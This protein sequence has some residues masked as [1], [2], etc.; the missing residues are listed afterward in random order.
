MGKLDG[1]VAVYLWDAATGKV[2]RP[3]PGT[4]E[5]WQVA[6]CPD[7]RRL[8][9]LDRTAL[10]IWDADTGKEQFVLTLTPDPAVKM[11]RQLV[12][13]DVYVR[14]GWA[15]GGKY[16]AALTS[17]S[18]VALTEARVTFFDAATGKAKGPP[19][20]ALALNGLGNEVWRWSPD[21]QRL[22]LAGRTRLTGPWG[23][24]SVTA[25]NAAAGRTLFQRQ[26][27]VAETLAWS[28]DSRR[29]LVRRPDESDP[30]AY[31][32]DTGHLMAARP[33]D[34]QAA[35]GGGPMDWTGFPMGNTPVR[36]GSPDGR[37]LARV[38][39][40]T[41]HVW[42]ATR[43]RREVP[44]FLY[45][46]FEHVSPDGTLAVSPK[47]GLVR[48]VRTE[49]V[50]HQLGVAGDWIDRVT[51]SPDGRWLVTVAT[52]TASSK[53][54]PPP[55]ARTDLRVRD[56]TTGAEAAYLPG[57]AE[58]YWSR[59]GRHF[60]YFDG[61]YV[62][63]RDP[64]RGKDVRRLPRTINGSLPPWAMTAGPPLVWSPDGRRLLARLASGGEQWIEVWDMASGRAL[65]SLILAGAPGTGP[66]RCLWDGDR[67]VSYN[68][69]GPLWT[70]D[71]ASDRPVQRRL[72]GLPPNLKP[73]QLT[74]SPDGRRWALA[75]PGHPLRIWDAAGGLKTYQWSCKVSP[76][77]CWSP[78]GQLL[79]L[80][81]FSPT[82]G[83]LAVVDL[84][85]GGE[86][87]ALP[88]SLRLPLQNPEVCFPKGNRF[89][90]AAGNTY[91]VFDTGSGRE[92][93]SF[94]EGSY[95]GPGS[96]SPDGGRLLLREFDKVSCR[97]LADGKTVF[98]FPGTFWDVTWG[99]DGHYLLICHSDRTY[100]CLDAATGK[101]VH[102]GEGKAQLS[103][104]GK[105]LLVLAEGKAVVRDL[106]R[107]NVVLALGGADRP[108]SP[109]ALLNNPWNSDVRW[110]AGCAARARSSGRWAETGS[111][112]KP[113]TGWAPSCRPPGATA[114]CCPS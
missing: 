17:K 5:V 10:K 33:G 98:T 37:L 79:A 57:V 9:T 32:A 23:Q 60:A 49:E 31:D 61:S 39:K 22:A 93:L 41:L 59:D 71:M 35:D 104:D 50:V 75:E 44:Q 24:Y 30:L 105:R 34:G 1:R 77:A 94:P 42:D 20:D 100:S 7:G 91:K 63:V 46:A 65:H 43:G 70:W 12:L 40:G 55:T 51:F 73:P 103:P 21:G 53:T 3:L 114:A 109:P 83:G 113:A 6:W 74:P 78:D 82:P 106:A 14:C 67:L 88:G 52:V 102:K 8:A 13:P 68:D 45:R 47:D 80:T 62:K 72:A 97:N 84:S 90:A 27:A 4:S 86:P 107:G 64:A 81:G 111:I 36:L 56:A 95:C 92:L 87:R 112:R 110:L 19:V 29:L 54:S 11:S 101:L 89:V 48:D 108:E 58:V 85:G 66:N 26:A 38:E 99:A 76:Q 69:S 2:R 15:P 28:S 25:L 16:L 96:W 18:T